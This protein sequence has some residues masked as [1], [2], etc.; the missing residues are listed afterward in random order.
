MVS[1]QRVRPDQDGPARSRYPSSR[2]DVIND[3]IA[4]GGDPTRIAEAEQHQA[5]GDDYVLGGTGEDLLFGGPG[6]DELRGSEE[7]DVICGEDGDDILGGGM[8]TDLLQGGD[9]D[10]TL[11]GKSATTLSLEMQ[12]RTRPMVAQETQLRRRN[13]S[14]L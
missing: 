14:E 7:N 3:A 2:W 6:N 13:R 5:I 4:R 8:G 12:E 11:E 1:S 9:G 10:D